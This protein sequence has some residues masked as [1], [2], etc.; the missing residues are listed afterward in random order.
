MSVQKQGPAEKS[1]EMRDVF[2]GIGLMI[3]ALLVLAAIMAMLDNRGVRPVPRSSSSEDMVWLRQETVE[4]STSAT[5]GSDSTARTL[6]GRIYAVHLDYG[7]SISATTDITVVASNPSL[8]ILQVDDYYTDTWYYPVA[9]RHS[10]AG[11]TVSD[12]AP[13]V[14]TS[15]VDIAVGQTTSG[16]QVVTATILWGR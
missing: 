10:S 4:V 1:W 3:I 7:A 14:A 5:S 9:Q 2:L 16:T 8:T 12:Y 11:A 6:H 13:F 15:A